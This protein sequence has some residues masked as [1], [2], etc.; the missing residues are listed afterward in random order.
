MVQCIFEKLLNNV[1][2]LFSGGQVETVDSESEI[3]DKIIRIKEEERFHCGWEEG[4]S[5]DLLFLILS[6][7]SAIEDEGH[8]VGE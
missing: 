2:S 6:Q 7:A 3:H 4:F 8:V 5:E 1:S